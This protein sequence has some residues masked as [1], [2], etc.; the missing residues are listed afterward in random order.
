MEIVTDG[1]AV[2]PDG[3]DGGAGATGFWTGATSSFAQDDAV[4]ATTS[5]VTRLNEDFMLFSAST[6]G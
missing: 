1:G 5:T 4:I 6:L 3:I 2:G